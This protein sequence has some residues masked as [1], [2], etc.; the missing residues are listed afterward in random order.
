MTYQLILLKMQLQFYNIEHNSKWGCAGGSSPLF[1]FLTHVVRVSFFR[2]GSIVHFELCIFE[3]SFN[4]DSSFIS[5]TLSVLLYT[6]EFGSLDGWR[7]KII[8]F[9]ATFLKRYIKRMWRNV[10]FSKVQCNAE[11][12][13]TNLVSLPHSRPYKIGSRRTE[14]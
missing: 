12:M 3:C 6:Q 11:R 4:P 2:D 8:L 7:K 5:L 10:F 9:C 14:N 13:I 1:S